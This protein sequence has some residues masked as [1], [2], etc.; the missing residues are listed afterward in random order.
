MQRIFNFEDWL[1][2]G[3]EN[4]F[5]FGTDDSPE[6]V[7]V[8]EVNA[9]EKCK[10]FVHDRHGEEHFLALVE[11]RD[12]VQFSVGGS[13]GLH[14]TGFCN[15]K[16]SEAFD[17]TVDPVDDTTF[18]TLMERRVRNEDLELMMFLANQNVEKRIAEQAAEF[19]RRLAALDASRDVLGVIAG[20]NDAQT[21]AA[22]SGVADGGTPSG[23]PKATD[24]G[25]APDG[26]AG[27]TPAASGSGIDDAA[28]K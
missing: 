15:I 10:L 22:G 17:H 18:T 27:G 7:V 3:P 1:K 25:G 16:T 8:L 14:T 9:E 24:G 13:W 11:G 2:C 23:E 26:G 4:M 6:R 19:E 20:V 21:F 28:A 5:S 12:E